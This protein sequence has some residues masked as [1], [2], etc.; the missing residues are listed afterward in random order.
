MSRRDRTAPRSL[1]S[2]PQSGTVTTGTVRDVVTDPPGHLT[3]RWPNDRDPMIQERLDRRA[4]R[5]VSQART[6]AQHTNHQPALHRS[7]PLPTRWHHRAPW[8]WLY[9][10]SSARS[11][12][13]RRC[14]FFSGCRRIS[15]SCLG[16]MGLQ[17]QQW[18]WRITYRFSNGGRA[19]E[20]PAIL[21]Q[22][23]PTPLPLCAQAHACA[24]RRH[25][26]VTGTHAF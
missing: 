23:A 20:L 21:R 1:P 12:P 18:A 8:F 17:S 2:P 15:M 19:G 25:T 7:P 6:Q 24:T 26:C 13:L 9:N 10:F 11:R 4:P 14:R 5:T 22:Q 16:R 3:R